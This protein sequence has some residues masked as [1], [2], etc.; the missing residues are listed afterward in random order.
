MTL[1]SDPIYF[2]TEVLSQELQATGVS[3][4]AEDLVQRAFIEIQRAEGWPADQAALTLKSFKMHENPWF[5]YGELHVER[6]KPDG[7]HESLLYFVYTQ[8][9]PQFGEEGKDIGKALFFKNWS[10]G[11]AEFRPERLTSSDFL[12]QLESTYLKE[13]LNHLDEALTQQKLL[14]EELFARKSRISEE[15]DA[16][17]KLSV[18]LL[19]TR[20]RKGKQRRTY[21][22]LK[23]KEAE[24][25]GIS[26][27]LDE[28]LF[29][30]QTM[31]AQALE[32]FGQD[33][34]MAV[35][36]KH[37]IDGAQQGEAVTRYE[38]VRKRHQAAV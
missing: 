24:L 32:L 13:S 14:V 23:E 1:V 18:R 28:A 12:N 36:Q 9:L 26:E 6:V 17:H 25:F 8:H 20:F 19:N 37:E 5:P 31:V 10:Y 30:Q 4:R 38:A 22:Q 7:S 33:Q 3:V 2:A 34:L 35:F 21:E 27:D 11:D 16:L 15:R 29:G